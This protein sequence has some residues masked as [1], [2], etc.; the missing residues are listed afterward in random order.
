M[1]TTAHNYSNNFESPS[2]PLLQF[3]SGDSCRKSPGEMEFYRIVQIKCFKIKLEIE[4]GKILFLILRLE[5]NIKTD[6]WT[7]E[8]I[9]IF[10]KYISIYKKKKE[11]EV[12]RR[13]LLI[14]K[15]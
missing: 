15:F 2:T 10:L 13:I 11:I 6:G 9:D 12:W 3:E 8:Y 5:I 4:F 14:D 7:N 1:Y